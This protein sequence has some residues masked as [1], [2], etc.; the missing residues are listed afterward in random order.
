L[1]NQLNAEH[2]INEKLTQVEF[3]K[4]KTSF[5]NFETC[6]VS[7]LKKYLVFNQMPLRIS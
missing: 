1:I 5:H 3:L 7:D 2:G 4:K 6:T